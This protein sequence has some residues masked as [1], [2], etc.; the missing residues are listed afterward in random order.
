VGG[1][2]P[3]PA[4]DAGAPRPVD[5]EGLP[6]P[7][8]IHGKW[9]RGL[10]KALERGESIIFMT[11]AAGLLVIAIAVFAE[12]IH[13]LVAAPPAEQFAVTITR[14]VNSALFIVVVLELV[15]TIIARLEGGGFQLQPFLVIGIISATRDIL[16][17]G[18]ELSLVGGQTPLVRSMTELGVNA[19]VVLALSV[20]L[21][22]VRRLARLDRV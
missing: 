6:R 2:D 12:G 15:R 14:A 10:L 21:V 16:T 8:P 13:A 1:A 17:V 3:R 7:P 20:A 22:L 5:D 11:I 19:G 9:P 18:A 4:D